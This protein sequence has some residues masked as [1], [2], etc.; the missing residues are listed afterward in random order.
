MPIFVGDT[1]GGRT[2][3][4]LASTGSTWFG[5]T[6]DDLH[7]FQ[8]TLYLT[9][10][11]V[12]NTEGASTGDFT[13]KSTTSTHM[14]FVDS[15]TDMI[16]IGTSSPAKELDVVG[17]IKVSDSLYTNKIRRATDNGTTTKIKL[18]SNEIQFY[19]GG[20]SSD[21]VCTVNSTGVGIGVTP[22]KALHVSSSN[23][24]TVLVQGGVSVNSGSCS[25][26][27]SSLKFLN[28]GYSHATV[29]VS[30]SA[31][32]IAET[33]AGGDAWLG[34]APLIT[35]GLGG[36]AS[37][38]G[39]GPSRGY[40]GIGTTSPN[41]T[42]HVAGAFAASGPSETFQTFANGDYTPSLAGG[43]LFKTYD[44]AGQGATS[45]DDGVAGQTVTIIST[46]AFTYMVS[47]GNLK[48]G[49]T[50]I[51]TAAGDVTTWIYDGTYWYLMNFMDQSTDL[52]GGH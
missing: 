32:V 34:A 49:T 45:M 18:E 5:N 30:G 31:F 48:G 13:V 19:A 37:G 24:T 29:G 22:G 38:G 39:S 20:N 52:S 27:G 36:D 7:N 16:G 12:F 25:S 35:V 4:T 26:Y 3:T 10:A 50:N 21:Q 33:S 8:G 44:G 47:G 6:S 17:N 46:N 42:L 15:S 41:C 51:T 23:D 9:G 40:V 1:T 14:F 43:N 11:A 2:A 28:A